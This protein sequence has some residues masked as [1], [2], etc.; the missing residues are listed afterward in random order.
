MKGERHT[1][2]V[3]VQFSVQNNCA[4]NQ[5]MK[6]IP[7]LATNSNY[8]LTIKHSNRIFAITPLGSVKLALLTDSTV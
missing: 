7:G 3:Y 4:R 8:T 2:H 5:T 6:Q 1:L